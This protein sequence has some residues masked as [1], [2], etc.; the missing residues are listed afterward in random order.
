MVLKEFY[1]FFLQQVQGIYSMNEAAI[2]TDWVF[3]KTA[4]LKRMDILLHPEQLIDNDHLQ[5]LQS[6]LEQLLQHMPVQY[7]LGEAWFCKMKFKVN[8]QV[9]IPRPETEELV[10]LI[11]N[12]D[13]RITKEL[14]LQIVD[15]GT[16]SG[17]IAIALKKQMPASTITAID[18]SPGAL[19]IAKENAANNN[20][21]VHFLQQDF[22][23]QHNWNSLPAYDIVV[24]NPP[25]IPINE[26]EK[27]DKNVVVYEPTTAL[28]VPDNE[29]LLF[30]K[31]IAAFGKGHL[32]KNGKI[33][34]EV[35]EGYAKETAN[36]FLLQ[37][38]TV[39]IKKDIFGKERI[40]TACNNI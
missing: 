6:C 39:E 26:K 33:F 20:T 5:K 1:R 29:P 30:Y 21:A 31:K 15:I 10:Q 18:I 40:V 19:D 36:Y 37:Y 27:M 13:Y 14:P 28:F 23:H 16:G 34:V 22:L 25:Y 35:H 2:I 9:L 7:V 17:C 11:A 24:S 8:D 3:E 12:N 32:N 4:S 38:N